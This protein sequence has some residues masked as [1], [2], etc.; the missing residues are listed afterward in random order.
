M[1]LLPFPRVLAIVRQRK[2]AETHLG[3]LAVDN[4]LL[5]VEEPGRDLVLGRVLEDGDDSLE[6]IGVELSGTASTR[7]HNELPISFPT[8]DEAERRLT[9][10]RDPHLPS[11]I[12]RLRSDDRHLESRSRRT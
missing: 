12:L 2:Y 4:V 8:S 1:S 11:C 5:P 10:C 9:A 6:L 7:M 3:V